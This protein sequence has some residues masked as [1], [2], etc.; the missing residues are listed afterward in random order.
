C[1]RHSCHSARCKE[2]HAS[3]Q[4]ARGVAHANRQLKK[5]AHATWHLKTKIHSQ[6]ASGSPGHFY[7][8]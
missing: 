7:L 3:R 5:V 2:S 1:S 8:A 6:S 4:E